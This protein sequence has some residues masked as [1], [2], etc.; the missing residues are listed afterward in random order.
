MPDLTCVLRDQCLQKLRCLIVQSWD[1]SNVYLLYCVSIRQ[2][3]IV[4]LCKDLVKSNCYSGH[5]KGSQHLWDLVSCLA[6]Q[7]TPPMAW[8]CKVLMPEPEK[9]GLTVH[10]KSFNAKCSTHIRHRSQIKRML[11]IY[12][13]MFNMYNRR[14]HLSGVGN[15]RCSSWAVAKSGRVVLGRDDN[16][17]LILLLWSQCTTH[18]PELCSGHLVKL[19]HFLRCAK[20]SK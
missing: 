13:S 20:V 3:M 12:V 9:M 2:S 7:V 17:N 14:F 16:A 10:S 6:L 19:L 4:P 8:S 15:L 11:Y 5:A 1:G 18:N